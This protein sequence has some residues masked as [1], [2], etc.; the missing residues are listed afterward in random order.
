M[1]L[2]TRENEGFKNE[3]TSWSTV[4]SPVPSFFM[5]CRLF[6]CEKA[7]LLQGRLDFSDSALCFATYSSCDLAY[8]NCVQLNHPGILILILYTRT[9]IALSQNPWESNTV[10]EIH[11]QNDLCL[12]SSCL[13]LPG[14]KF[15]VQEAESRHTSMCC[16][17]S[18][19]WQAT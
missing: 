5:G 17:G 13:F 16:S 2:D 15:L 1:I 14:V 12:G 6:L 4:T 18:E 9:A 11:L 8:K 7:S 19:S 3:G 10:T